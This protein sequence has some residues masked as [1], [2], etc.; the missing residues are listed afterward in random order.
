MLLELGLWSA[1]APLALVIVSNIWN[2]PA[3]LEEVVKWGILRL[4]DNNGY[5]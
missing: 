2:Y 3:V 4:A 1:V 5:F